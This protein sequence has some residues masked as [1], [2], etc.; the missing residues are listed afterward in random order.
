MSALLSEQDLREAAE[1]RVM[2]KAGFRRHALFYCLV[3][4]GLLGLNLVTSPQ[5]LWA[6]WSI[7]GW[8]IGLAAHGLGVYGNHGAGREAEIAREMERMR[9]R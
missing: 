9:G 8:G 5:Y 4:G 1:R 3:N 6:G 7:F 2:A